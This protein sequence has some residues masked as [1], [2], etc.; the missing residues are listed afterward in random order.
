MK[1]FARLLLIL[2]VACILL[3]FSFKSVTAQISGAVNDSTKP[4]AVVELF[5]SESCSSCPSADKLLSQLTQA[6]RGQ[7]KRIFTLGFHVDY[8]NYL[9]WVDEYSKREYSQRQREYA[10]KLKTDHVYTPQMIING[11][12][13]F[14]GNRQDL[15][16]QHIDRALRKPPQFR[17]DLKIM[18]E[19]D[20]SI[21]VEYKLSSFIT[22]SV[23]NVALVERNLSNKISSGENAGRLLEH[24]NVVRHLEVI[25]LKDSK[26][27]VRLEKPADLKIKDASI[28][29][30]LQ[31]NTTMAILGANILD[32]S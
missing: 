8:W 30:Y 31:N 20:K 7:N 1:T 29:V 24:A 28:I 14:G 15:A 32:L 6:A 25:F 19:T 2:G 21:M 12:E 18:S 13:E 16:Q 27:V 3:T 17:V 26:G 23:L 9:S 5:T 10:T 4:F 22:N 11:S